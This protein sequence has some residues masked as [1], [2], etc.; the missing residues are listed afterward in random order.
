MSLKKTRKDYWSHNYTSQDV[1]LD[2]LS[3]YAIGTFSMAHKTVR[4]RPPLRLLVRTNDLHRVR[5]LDC[6]QRIKLTDYIYKYI[7][8][9]LVV[10][11][12]FIQPRIYSHCTII[13]PSVSFR[14][15]ARCTRLVCMRITLYRSSVRW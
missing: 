7:Y 1:L 4:L 2:E 14:V 3:Y 15:D 11:E 12:N 10:S 8:S 13:S 5:Y 9:G 6:W